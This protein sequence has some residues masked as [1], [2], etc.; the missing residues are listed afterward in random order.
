MKNHATTKKFSFGHFIL[1][2]ITVCFSVVLLALGV[3]G[4]PGNPTSSELVSD[5]WM[6]D[7]PFELSP[8]RGR[9]GLMYSVMEDN[10]F[11]F[12]DDIAAFTSPDNAMRA[13]GKVVSLFAPAVSY[14]LIPGYLV[15]KQFSLAQ[16]GASSVILVFALINML[17]IRT[18]AIRLGAHP[19]AATVGALAF[20]FATPAFA[21]AASI[22]QHHISTFLIL[23][24]LYLLIRFKGLWSLLLIWLLVALSIPVD[25]PN[26]FLLFPIAIYAGL[27][28]FIVEDMKEKLLIR[29]R[30]L[31]LLTLITA[32][33]PIAL[34]L[35]YNNAAY[36]NPFQLS[37]TLQ[38]VQQ[39][40]RSQ[41]Q[42]E[43]IET[44][45]SKA[46]EGLKD[47]KAPEIKKTAVGFFRSRLLFSGF[48]T[49]FVSPD[50]GILF[51]TPV[52]FF[53]IAGIIF[54][55]KRREGIFGVL[56]AVIGANVL[57]YSMWGDPYG[58]W[59]FGSRYLIP[60]YAV[61]SIFIALALTKLKRSNLFILSFF[62]ILAFSIA[63][64]ALGAVTTNMNPPQVEAEGLSKQT[65]KVEKYTFE[66]NFDFLIEEGSKSY[67][68]RTYLAQN[69]LATDYYLFVSM[70]LVA[71][72]GMLLVWL[73]VLGAQRRES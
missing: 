54:A 38:T 24:S 61:S 73:R 33:I 34:F 19:I 40:Q 43:L 63:V 60:T 15:G 17:L 72:T 67:I 32:I 47:E 18:I 52:M 23:A 16:V 68:Y 11:V 1:L 13:D 42:N 2:L 48:Y 5:Y 51:F 70:P 28:L 31:G 50:R 66:R 12:S 56:L 9:Y 29:F 37:G 3:R 69:M 45:Q 6:K 53:G 25:Y 21:Y 62:I 49:H 55:L 71:F 41:Q 35:A 44:E 46:L 64:N 58:G 22:Y 14:F 57:L 26:F 65:G 10:S 8:E 36:G 39:A 59:A 4:L 7:G 30:F 20:L 27:R